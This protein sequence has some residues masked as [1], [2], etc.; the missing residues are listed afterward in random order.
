MEFDLSLFGVQNC[1]LQYNN[2]GVKL[3]MLMLSRYKS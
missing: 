3:V 1:E 2:G